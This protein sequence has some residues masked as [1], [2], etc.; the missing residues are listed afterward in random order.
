MSN[1]RYSENAI[2]AAGETVS[3]IVNCDKGKLVGIV[4]PSGF[5]GASFTFLVCQTKGGTYQQL[6]RAS[7]GAAVTATVAL[8]KH[9]VV[10]PDDF[11]SAKFIK[12]VSSATEV[13]AVTIELILIHL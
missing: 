11:F 13:A 5:D 9:A 12:I 6:V 1:N 4:T 2:I 8:S 10:D 3:G 7:D